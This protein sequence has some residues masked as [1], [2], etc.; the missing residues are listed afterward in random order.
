MSDRT[1][2]TIFTVLWGVLVICA[3]ISLG[4]GFLRSN[5]VL[6]VVA[7]VATFAVV[8][9]H[10]YIPMP[11]VYAEKGITNDLFISRRQRM[12]NEEKRKQQ[13]ESAE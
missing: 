4:L 12:I 8:K 13:E 5:I 10:P 1:R 6:I 11:D 2:T 3:L 9:T 7:A